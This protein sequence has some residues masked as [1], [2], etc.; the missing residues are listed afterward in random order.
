VVIKVW[1]RAT[2]DRLWGKDPNFEKLKALKRHDPDSAPD[3]RMEVAEYIA[4]RL[5]ELDW[6]VSY[7]E[8]RH[9]GSPKPFS[10]SDQG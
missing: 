5:Q 9:P 2:P 10:G 4:A 6:E 1:L 7:L 8:P 3:P